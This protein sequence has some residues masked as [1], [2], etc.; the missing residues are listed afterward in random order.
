[1]K[2]FA[3]TLVAIVFGAT[4]LSAPAVGISVPGNSCNPP[5]GHGRSGCHRGTASAGPSAAQIKA[6]AAAKAAARAKTRAKA[7]AALKRA[8]E[9]RAAKAAAK[10]AAAQQAADALAA[11]QAAPATM[12]A[13]VTL[14]A[15]QA[16]IVPAVAKLTLPAPAKPAPEPWWLALWH[17]IAR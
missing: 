13:T 9:K 2:K 17:L 8:A 14:E 11:A 3:A 1:M 12:P 5:A 15:T 4:L 7:K 16:P 10:A 6:N